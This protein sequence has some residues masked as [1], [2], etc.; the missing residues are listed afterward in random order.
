VLNSQDSDDNH[1]VFVDKPMESSDWSALLGSIRDRE[2]I[3]F[4]GAGA[5]TAPPG[6]IGL[7][8]A[9]AISRELADECSYP[10]ADKSDFLR[11]CQFIELKEG[12]HRLRKKIIKKLTIPDLQPGRLHKLIA[13][14]PIQYVLTT[15]YDT[16]M[17]SAFRDAGRTPHV[18]IY[19][20]DE[21]QSEPENQVDDK[22]P[23]VY[24]LHGSMENLSSMLCTEDDIVQFLAC[25]FL[26][27]PPL[28]PSVRKLFRSHTILFVGYGL[29]D[30]NIRAM[31]RALRVKRRSD[32]I[33][34]FALQRKFDTS[35]TAAADW[36]QSVLYWDKKENVHCLDVDA[37]E[38]FEELLRRY[39]G[40]T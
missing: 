20:I 17:E 12:G 27:D 25:L 33:R 29:K 26:G 1:V 9:G 14:L 19:D 7:P 15:N 30:W 34:S 23:L 4:L 5:S 18:T 36:Q 38:F 10:G 37:I 24:K 8:T 6:E 31:I 35:L 11:V 13:E 40:E 22:S 21:S 16:L 28:L 3:V 39:R 32:W 2:C